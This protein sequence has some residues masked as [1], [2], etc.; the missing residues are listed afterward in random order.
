M[1][2][3]AL[4]RPGA[5]LA[6][7]FA[8]VGHARRRALLVDYDG[9][10]APLTADRR[11]AEPWEGIRAALVKVAHASRPTVLWI[12]SG[13]TVSDLARL[14]RLD[15]V[16]DLWG[17]HGLERR[18]RQGCWSGPAPERDAASFLDEVNAVLVREGAAA[19]LERK[20]YGVAIHERGADP[21][22]WAVARD[23]LERRFS[24]RAEALGLELLPFDGGLE[25][26]PRAFH[27]GQVVQRA[28]AELGEGA[29]V[30]YLG[31]DRTD[32]D[33]FAALEDRPEGLGVLV[34]AEPRPTRA[35]AWL[36]PPEEVLAFLQEWNTA[37]SQGAA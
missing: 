8:G 18:S 22:V 33:A 26:R 12:V 29:V 4:L 3:P 5:D 28:F 34:R 21:A 36:R 15:H 2:R 30:A 20:V 9:T 13:R 19:L 11:H 31:D 32:E 17:S 10:L 14:A 1:E 35:R 25:L 24:A 6:G 37:C 16:A 7:F 23:V 27:K